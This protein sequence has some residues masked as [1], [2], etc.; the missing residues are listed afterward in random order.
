M[1]NRFKSVWAVFVT[2]ALAPAVLAQGA[3]PAIVQQA[4]DATDQLCSTTERNQA[5]YGNVAV[6]ALAQPNVTELNF[7]SAGDIVDVSAIRTLRLRPMDVNEQTWGVVMMR[8]QANLPGSLPGQNVTFLLF[9]DVELTNAVTDDNGDAFTPM[10][11]FLLRTGV[12][13][14]QCEEAPSS[15]LIVQTPEGAGEVTFNINGVEVGMGSTV[16]F[17]ARPDGEMIVSTIE[18]AAVLEVE[19]E[20]QPV[21]AGSRLRVPLDRALRPH[22]RLINPPEPY[23]LRNLQGIPIRLLERRIDIA[24]PLTQEQVNRIMQRLL[25]GEPICGAEGLPSCDRIPRTLLARAMR[26]SRASMEERLD[27]VFRRGLRERPLQ[28]NESRPFCDELPPES[29]PC[30]FLPGA[31]DPALPPD[32]TRP[33]CPQLP[34]GTTLRGLR[35]NGPGLSGGG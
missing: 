15:G 35:Q 24:P 22:R 33:F 34:E 29:L 10:Q 23:E 5:C 3:C 28:A 25:N 16:M 31:D 18:G 21:L 6:D 8:L 2:L 1:L 30:V 19:D 27:C 17:R 20:V 7:D 26:A 14:S 4:L 12:G 13:D 32:E 11:A 9:G